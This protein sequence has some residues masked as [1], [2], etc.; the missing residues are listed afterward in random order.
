MRIIS[1][2]L[3][4]TVRCDNAQGIAGC[5]TRWTYL[6]KGLGNQRLFTHQ[7]VAVFSTFQFAVDG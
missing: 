6:Y 3:S 4:A 7:L 5:P 2:G 1:I